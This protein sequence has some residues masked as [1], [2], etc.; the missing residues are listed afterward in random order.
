MSW[1]AACAKSQA[2]IHVTAQLIDTRNEAQTWAEKYDRDI[3]DVFQIQSD[4]SQAIV[5]QL[6]VALS[7]SEKAAI[8]EQPT[9]DQEAYDLYLR[10]RALVYEF[11]V[12]VKAAQEDMAKAVMLLESAIAR[13]PKFTLAYCLLSEAQLSLYAD[14]YWNK[15][16][17]PKAKEALDRALSISP[18]SPQAHL[19]LAQYLYAHCAIPRPRKR[20]WPL[21][22]RACRETSKF[23]TLGQQSRNSVGDGR[24]PSS[25]VRK[26]ASSTREIRRQPGT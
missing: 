23:S 19:A 24:K 17:L 25:I 21:R 16:R 3:A 18:K 1:K 22:Q 14:E 15:E 20:S 9:Q 26:Q 5:A 6:K 7:P 10:A 8:E 13:D 12:T 2:R 11:G 4:I